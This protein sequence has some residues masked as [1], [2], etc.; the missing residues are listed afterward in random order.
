MY[1]NN[2]TRQNNNI[3]FPQFNALPKKFKSVDEYLIRG[4]HPCI[5]DIFA[6]K[7]EG[8]NK[9]YDFRH[10]GLRGFK[11]VERLGCK[12]ANVEYI[13]KPYSFLENKLPT[14]SDYEEIAKDVMNNGQ[15]GGKILFHCNSGTHRTSLMVAFYDITKGKSLNKCKT[16][17]SD[18]EKTVNEAIEKHVKNM[19]YFSRNKVVINTKNPIKKAK[20][21]FNNMVE[22]AICR[23]YNLF[24]EMM[25]K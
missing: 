5:H 22:E 17:N 13:R 4:P 19:K 9:I 16:E 1:I 15:K 25:Q 20:N 21:I 24:M 3:S 8:V 7:K 14:Q 12:L 23:A 11:W 10:Y 6:L 2:Y 18:F